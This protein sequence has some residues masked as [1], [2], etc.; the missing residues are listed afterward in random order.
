MKKNEQLFYLIKS[1]NKAEKR[2][3]KISTDAEDK[4]KNYI[5]LFNEIDSQTFYDEK[6]IKKKF[7]TAVFIK[8]LHVTKNY[9]SSQILKS[10][11]VYHSKNSID[12]KLN[13]YL[14]DVEILF[15]RELFEQCLV[16]V[17]IAENLANEYEKFCPLIEILNWKRKIMLVQGGFDKIQTNLKE[18]VLN[19]KMF[20]DKLINQN[21]YWL[22]TSKLYEI[23]GADDKAKRKFTKNKYLQNFEL[24]DSLQSKILYYHIQ[25]TLS[26]TNN[27]I[28]DALEFISKL[29]LLLEKNPKQ[30]SEE[31]S[32][33]ITSLNNKISLLL[34]TKQYS[35][36]PLLLTKVRSVPDK[37]KVKNRDKISVKLMV[38]TYNVE[39]EMYRDLKEFKKAE[40]L[41]NEIQHFLS[42]N[43]NLVT[44]NYKTLFFYQFAY[45]FF[46]RNKL[47]EAL[48][49]TN[50]LLSGKITGVREDL[51]SYVRFLNLM[52]HLE[53]GNTIVLK[54][55]VDASRR[56]LKK[57]RNLYD[58]EKVLLK[59][60]SKISL[61][62][63][64]EHKKMF[65][66]LN[67]N[68]FA[69]TDEIKKVDVL[70][71]IDF[72]GWIRY[73]L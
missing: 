26:T 9:L 45:I 10:L 27:K 34:S 56:F 4:N 1:M 68:L 59:F 20:L 49:W 48:H 71:Y 29:I 35:E 33:Y 57:K 36:I 53:L 39:L 41:I 32:S 40:N 3:F 17:K 22:M 5:L 19:Q 11:R 70:D 44:N 14:L 18:L 72:V 46:M 65:A 6:L 69:K 12:I 54:Y 58:F 61:A 63:K 2:H 64:S 25:Y 15:K 50:E 16:V 43:E 67:K 8:Q 37:Y 7:K 31:P 24:A 13:N 21:E 28:S 30:I 47:S 73:K 60:F 55:A 66:E 38:R 62:R 52:I 42:L 23:F 51:K